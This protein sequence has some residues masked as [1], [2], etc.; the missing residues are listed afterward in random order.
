MLSRLQDR[1]RR[2]RLAEAH[3]REEVYK[4]R[5]LDL[6]RVGVD[7]NSAVFVDTFTSA[8]AAHEAY[9]AQL[10]SNMR[11]EQVKQKVR[12]VQTKIEEQLAIKDALEA[13]RR[14]LSPGLIDRLDDEEDKLAIKEDLL[15]E[16]AERCLPGPENT[17]GGLS[18]NEWLDED[19]E[20]LLAK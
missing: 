7:K 3:K 6:L 2:L 10:R 9:C 8:K 15:T 19:D 12:T 13:H 11:V 1:Q 4:A 14:F 16:V 18:G 5:A 17:I 20:A